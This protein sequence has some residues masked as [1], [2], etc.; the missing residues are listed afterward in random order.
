MRQRIE[1]AGRTT[2]SNLEHIGVDNGVGQIGM[3]QQ[4]LHRS[5]V[6]ARLQ[7]VRGERV[8]QGVNEYRLGNTELRHRLLQFNLNSGLPA[9]D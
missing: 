9:F 5:D 6:G 3:P 2:G 1:R 8:A 7:Q 4:R